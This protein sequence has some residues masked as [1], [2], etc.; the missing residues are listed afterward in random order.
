MKKN[1]EDIRM[2]EIERALREL[3]QKEERLRMEL[4]DVLTDVFT[5]DNSDVEGEE[6]EESSMPAVR[7]ALLRVGACPTRWTHYAGLYQDQGYVS[8]SERKVR[9]MKKMVKRCRLSEVML[10]QQFTV[11]LQKIEE[12][13]PDDGGRK[14]LN[15]LVAC[16]HV[17]NPEN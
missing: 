13:Y 1:I 2:E 4:M 5:P 10:N 9:R 14:G 8:R 7:E 17:L 6:I 16:H 15:S 3:D 11:E 12:T